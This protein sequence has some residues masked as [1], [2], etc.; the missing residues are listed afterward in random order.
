LIIFLIGAVLIPASMLGAAS[1]IQ[2]RNQPGNCAGVDAWLRETN[3][4]FSAAEGMAGSVDRL[5]GGVS[6]ADLLRVS[7]SY[8]QALLAQ[9]QSNPPAPAQSVN[10]LVATYFQ[11][12]SENWSGWADNSYV[13]VHNYL[14]TRDLSSQLHD[15]EIAL[16]AHCS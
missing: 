2:I 6:A 7:D 9:M 1:A 11:Y 12:M 15:A 14:A 5:G 10:K 3:T 16:D 4:R 13:T 8:H